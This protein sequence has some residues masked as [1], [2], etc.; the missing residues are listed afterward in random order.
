[1]ILVT[2][3]T[4]FLG[5]E[6]A[7]QL[8]GNGELIVCIKRSAS[9]IPPMLQPYGQQIKWVDADVLDIFALED[10]MQGVTQVYHCAA[11]VSFNPADNRAMIKTNVEGTANVVNA[12]IQNNARL[13]HVSSVAALG[14]AKPGQLINENNHLEDTLHSDGYALSKYEGE[15]EV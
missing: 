10:A 5:S 1:M 6:V 9:I 3:A 14:E 7:K 15:M 13:V 12:C 4:G 2:G 11:I 8:A